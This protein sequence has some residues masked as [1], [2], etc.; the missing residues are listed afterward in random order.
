MAW[1][2]L[3]A[4][5]FYHCDSIFFCWDGFIQIIP[6]NVHIMKDHEFGADDVF[7]FVDDS[8][9]GWCSCWLVAVV[10]V[11][12]AV[13]TAGTLLEVWSLVVILVL[14]TDV[15][16]VELEVDNGNTLRSRMWAGINLLF[17]D[18]WIFNSVGKKLE[19]EKRERKKAFALENDEKWLV[20]SNNF[21][22][23]SNKKA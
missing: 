23:I 3:G 22:Y 1:F 16:N 21:S 12:I 5:A 17:N 13:V 14:L 4:V 11:A 10:L 18:G 15:V 19:K 20:M 7:E 8:V 6:E 2:I 9:A